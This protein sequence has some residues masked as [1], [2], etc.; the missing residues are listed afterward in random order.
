[1]QQQCERDR[2]EIG[3]PGRAC[4]I[5]LAI[6]VEGKI[7]RFENV[8]AHQADDRFIAMHMSL[9]RQQNRKPRCRDNEKHCDK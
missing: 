7:A 1:M 9:R 6:H 3:F 4:I 8:F 2:S 5:R